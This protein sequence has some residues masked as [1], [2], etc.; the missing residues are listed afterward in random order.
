MQSR[1]NNWQTKTN[2]SS[3]QKDSPCWIF[4][5]G[6]INI[7]IFSWLVT[8]PE[9]ACPSSCFK[10]HLHHVDAPK[11]LPPF[12][13]RDPLQRRPGGPWRDMTVGGGRRWFYGFF[14]GFSGDFGFI[15]LYPL[16][17]CES[18][19]TGKWPIEFVDLPIQDGEFSYSC[20]SLPEGMYLSLYIYIHIYIH[21]FDIYICICPTMS[22]DSQPGHTRGG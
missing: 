9:T 3:P 8:T 17:M 19:R 18:L 21:N 2:Y 1:K 5:H 11:Q 16:V 12:E 7:C 6:F 14:M 10:V 15:M 4:S 20:V 13:V 22:H